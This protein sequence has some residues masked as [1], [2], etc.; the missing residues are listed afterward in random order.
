M[1]SSVTHQNPLSVPF[2]SLPP[3]ERVRE[4]ERTE[5]GCRENERGNEGGMRGNTGGMRSQPKN[6]AS[7]PAVEPASQPANRTAIVMTSQPT[8]Q[9]TSEP[10]RPPANRPPPGDDGRGAALIS[11]WIPLRGAVASH[12]FTEQDVDLDLW[13]CSQPHTP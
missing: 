6:P 13:W 2:R 5:T 10:A 3:I 4:R 7:Q 1:G 12:V 9:P 11:G 8:S